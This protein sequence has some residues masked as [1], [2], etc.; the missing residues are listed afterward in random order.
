MNIKDFEKIKPIVRN[1]NC[2]IGSYQKSKNPIILKAI[3]DLKEFTKNLPEEIDMKARLYCFLHDIK[4]YPKC[5]LKGCDNLVTYHSRGFG[6]YC[7]D[8]HSKIGNPRHKVPHTEEG[9]KHMKEA[10]E[11][12]GGHKKE[13]NSM[14]DKKQSDYCK[15]RQSEI[16][17]GEIRTQEWIDDWQSK[18]KLN[19]EERGIKISTT[20]KDK[21][22]NHPE[23]IKEWLDKQYETKKKN[24]SFNKS[25][26]E[27]NIYEILKTIYP[28]II[29]NYNEKRY[30]FNC[31][32]YIPDLDLF[33]E[34]NGNWHHYIENYD[35]DKEEHKK[36]I[37]KWKIKAI[38]KRK[39]NPKKTNQ[40]E[41]ALNVF[42]KRDPE[43]VKIAKKSK[44]NFLV[45]W[46]LKDFERF[47]STD[48]FLQ[49]TEEACQIEFNTIKNKIPF[50]NYNSSWNKI[51][52]NYQDHFYKKEK[53]LWKTDLRIRSKLLMNRSFYLNKKIQNITDYELLRGFKISGIYYGFSFHSPFWI[54]KFIEDYEIKSVYDP[55][56]GW[57]HRL[58]GASKIKYI[59][60][61]LDSRSCE[62]IRNIIKDF[63]IEN[64]IVYNKDST[65][66]TP[67]EN[68]ECVFTCPPYFNIEIYNEKTYENDYR[69]WLDEFWKK[70]VKNSLKDSVKYFCFIINEKYK[71][72]MIEICKEFN[73][74]FKEEIKV[75]NNNKN[76]FKRKKNQ[77]K[78]W[79]YLVI[80]QK[81]NA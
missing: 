19:A 73:L 25:N 28:N 51:I 2:L 54:K 43:K 78:N 52:L 10:I 74:T 32:F 77:D 68:Y 76:H 8:E 79:E 7:S 38:E 12:S 61:D 64:K 11:K 71:N 55:C 67:E 33:I 65:K 49:F 70:L 9:K 69:K 17:K 6:E 37:E 81:Q 13:K 29:R 42:I 44:I 72:D 58:L 40:Y 47:L 30:P 34:Y 56:G 45:L 23:L 57:G 15:Q 18:M 50:Y 20:F 24:N 21:Q 46:N 63:N 3:E 60:N 14:W 4:E 66:F 27:N 1:E 22:I 16:H 53:E 5:K 31:D 75:G 41:V 26:P 62:G 80:M 39:E 59:Y 35:K 36:L 48:L